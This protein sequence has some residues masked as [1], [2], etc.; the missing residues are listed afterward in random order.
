MDLWKKERLLLFKNFLQ[1]IE[2]EEI[3]RRHWL[4]KYLQYL[5]NHTQT[6]AIELW[7]ELPEQL[8]YDDFY[9][10]NIRKNKIKQIWYH[11]IL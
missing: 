10:S 8:P 2:N 9:F 11:A 1:Y 3:K 4:L 7:I 5:F 6:D